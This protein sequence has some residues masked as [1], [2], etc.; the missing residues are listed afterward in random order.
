MI[1]YELRN[2]NMSVDKIEETVKGSLEIVQKWFDDWTVL[3][4]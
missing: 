3:V 4:E 1:A 2:R